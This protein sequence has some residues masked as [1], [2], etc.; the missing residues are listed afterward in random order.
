MSLFFAETGDAL[1]RFD[2]KR[3]QGI[4]NAI[5][6]GIEFGE[7]RL[8]FFEFENNRVTERLRACADHVGKVR[9]LRKS[10]HVS[11]VVIFLLSGVWRHPAEDNTGVYSLPPQHVVPRTLLRDILKATSSSRNHRRC[12]EWWHHAPSFG[13]CRV[14]MRWVTSAILPP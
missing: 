11:P 13:G 5:G 12:N 2:A 1:S 6:L 4:G 14:A 7:A 9:R 8:A 10:G 3:V